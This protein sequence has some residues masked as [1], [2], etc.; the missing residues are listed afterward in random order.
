MG[1]GHVLCPKNSFSPKVL[2]TKAC[3]SPT[4][5][6]VLGRKKKNPLFHKADF[7]NPQAPLQTPSGEN[8]YS[9]GPMASHSGSWF[10]GQ[11]Q[12]RGSQP[13]PHVA[14]PWEL[15]TV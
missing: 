12:P 8:L 13:S 6:L 14:I 3:L 11:I 10:W 4:A 9:V 1:G 5:P 2:S 7:G 15:Q